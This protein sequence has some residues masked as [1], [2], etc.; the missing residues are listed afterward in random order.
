MGVHRHTHRHPLLSRAINRSLLFVRTITTPDRGGKNRTDRQTERGKVLLARIVM[1]G[2]EGDGE[3]FDLE[4]DN[5][6]Y[7][8]VSRETDCAECR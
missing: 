4:T 2:G 8:I 5:F 3:F 6:V 7:L 1:E